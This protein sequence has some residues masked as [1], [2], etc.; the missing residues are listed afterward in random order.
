MNSSKK[1]YW[2]L[3]IAFSLPIQASER[4]IDAAAGC[5]AQMFVMTSAG[6]SVEG[7]GK[8][9]EQ[10][11][12]FINMM[13]GLYMEN[14]TGKKVTNRMVSEIREA[15]LRSY[16]SSNVSALTAESLSNCL[17]WSFSLAQ[18]LQ[19]NQGQSKQQLKNLLLNGP[20]PNGQFDYPFNDAQQ[21]P[22]WVLLAK[23][24]WKTGG[25]VT[26]GKVREQLS[27]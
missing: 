23:Q 14:Q 6:R 24:N 18:T 5:A 19:K 10:Q 9:F 16:E 25:Y 11:S 7:L 27:K 1:F 13:L 12:G 26:P 8:Y 21:L 17:G 2:V 20:K 22:N 3:V 15:K 4:H